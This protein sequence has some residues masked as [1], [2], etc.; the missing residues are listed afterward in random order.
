MSVAIAEQL[1]GD[2]D[3]VVLVVDQDAA[4][5]VAGEWVE[6]GEDCE[7]LGIIL[8]QPGH[9]PKIPGGSALVTR[10]C[11]PPAERSYIASPRGRFMGRMR[12]LAVV[13]ALGCI[14][15]GPIPAH[16]GSVW[17]PNDAAHRLDI[18]WVGVYHQADG[19]MRITVAFHDRIR[20]RWF[21][22]CSNPFLHSCPRPPTFLVGF[23]TRFAYYALFF[24][25]RH[26]GLWAQ[27]CEGGSSCSPIAK[28]FRPDRKTMRVRLDEFQGYGPAPG[29]YFRAMSFASDGHTGI[30][31][32]H[33]GIIT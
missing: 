14:M 32:T 7:K 6:G 28:V 17:D 9:A 16:A 5:G 26:H 19:R 22:I 11:T 31:R 8:G 29:W 27:L 15:L 12:I 25:H 21:P 4:E 30:D 2:R 13:L 10:P 33:R 23:P 18:R 24:R 1:R 20:N 3:A